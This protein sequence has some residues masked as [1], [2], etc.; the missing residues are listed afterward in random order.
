MPSL[1]GMGS[2]R[3]NASLV[4]EFSRHWQTSTADGNLSL[5]GFRRFKTA[6]LLNLRFLEAEIAELDRIIYQ[7]GLGLNIEP[8]TVDRLGLQHA[9]RDKSPPS[10]DEK[11]S[12]DLLR[13]LRRLLKEYGEPNTPYNPWCY[14]GHILNA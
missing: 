11:L 14:K 3:D 2:S 9:T 4:D 8:S 7:L 1:R 6:H 12:T 10:L 13:K 5:Y